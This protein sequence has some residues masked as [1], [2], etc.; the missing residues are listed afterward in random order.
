MRGMQKPIRSDAGR[1]IRS[2]HPFWTGATAA[3][4]RNK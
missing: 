4:K 3:V 2:P 1:R